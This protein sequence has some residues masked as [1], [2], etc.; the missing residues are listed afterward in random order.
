ML[1][2]LTHKNNLANLFNKMDVI[3]VFSRDLSIRIGLDINTDTDIQLYFWNNDDRVYKMT[4]ASICQYNI[5]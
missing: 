3:D 4:M 2:R 5:D 1:W